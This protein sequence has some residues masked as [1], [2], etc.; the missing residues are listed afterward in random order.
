M[1]IFSL[2]SRFKKGKREREEVKFCVF[3]NYCTM[4]DDNKE[5]NC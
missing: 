2:S 3:E 5:G 4:D 1:K